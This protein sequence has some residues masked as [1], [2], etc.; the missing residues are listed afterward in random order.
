MGEAS[1][2]A[3]LANDKTNSTDSMNSNNS[4]ETVTISGGEGGNR[5]RRR[6]LGGTS[7]APSL[8]C[9]AMQRNRWE[10]SRVATI[11]SLARPSGS[12]V[13]TSKVSP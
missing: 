12:V 6:R 13:A 1:P 11:F 3:T 7:V 5:I 4:T 9:A 10:R 2:P 8:D